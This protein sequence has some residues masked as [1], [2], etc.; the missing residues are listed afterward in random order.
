MNKK[1]RLLFAIGEIDEKYVK[2]AESRMNVK[3]MIK[4]AAV[5]I[6]VV[7]LSMYLFIPIAAPTTNLKA[8]KE[9]SYYPLIEG[10]DNYMLSFNQPKYKNNFEAI[11][12]AILSLNPPLG[13][14]P[15]N[16]SSGAPE[17]EGNG[18]YVESTDN[19]V[20]GVIESDLFKMT[21]KYIFRLGY[22]MEYDYQ[23][24]RYEQYGLA[25]RVYSIEKENSTLISQFNIPKFA[26]QNGY[27]DMQMYLSADASTV[28][29]MMNYRGTNSKNCVGLVSIDVSDVTNMS[30]KGQTLV[31]GTINTTRY[32]DGR[33]LLVTDYSFNRNGVDYGSPDT[34]VP[35]VDSG[36]GAECIEFENII[37]PEEVSGTAYSV[38]A[39]FDADSLRVL[40]AHALLN[41]TGNV[42]VSADN[43]YITREYVSKT[44][45]GD[46]VFSSNMSDIAVIGYSEGALVEK[47][48]ITVKGHTED[49]FSFDEKDGYLRV[50][51]STRDRVQIT[52]GESIS[53]RT[54]S[55]NVSLFI[56]DL[57][58]NSV[59]Y[60]LE[61]FAIEGEEAT[62]VRFDGD[63]C[64]VCTAV[65]V[66]FTDPVYFID[67][68]DYENIGS[69][70]T[71]V[72]EGFSDSLIN[73]GEGLLLGIGR[74]NWQYMKVEIYKQE[75]DKVSSVH[76]FK[77][78]GNY[79]LYYKAFLV[80]REENLFGFGV[81]FL[82]EYD[83]Q[84]GIGKGYPCYVLLRFDENEM[85]VIKYKLKV[86][87]NSVRAAYIDGYLYITTMTELFV[88]KVD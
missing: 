67:L 32:A 81:D 16:N 58:D 17:M 57:K 80:N 29:V 59:A 46:S 65:V 72:I 50:V 85:T 8:Y 31:E 5:L 75:G 41:F 34:F 42:Y 53:A 64:Y 63:M 11:M 30:V 22:N 33:I 27:N 44:E 56:V 38:V 2:E 48:I 4:A 55:E 9:S 52:N 60:S 54:V 84:T 49:Q 40:G 62:A 10:I 24:D 21:D 70:D 36:N 14:A 88:E 79:A 15:G 3:K 43:L 47:G 66:T 26:D 74:E 19:Q 23:L 18:S 37:Y 35:T 7:A 77:F 13:S 12:D 61:S 73:Y 68:S 83:E 51:T 28:T 6:V 71:G 1:E 78:N 39:L 76:K 45:E 86:D 69:V 20:E 82:Y 25:L 87:A